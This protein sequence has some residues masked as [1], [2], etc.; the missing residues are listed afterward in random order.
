MPKSFSSSLNKAKALTQVVSSEFCEIG[1][2]SKYKSQMCA[3]VYLES[4]YLFCIYL[5]QI[6]CY[7]KN[8]FTKN[9]LRSYL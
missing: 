3:N 1:L 5:N 4:V 8:L 7:K 6:C 9:D 2:T